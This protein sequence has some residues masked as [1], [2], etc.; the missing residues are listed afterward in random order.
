[1]RKTEIVVVDLWAAEA[2]LVA[3]EAKELGMLKL[4]NAGEKIHG[5]ML[6][7]TKERY[8]EEVAQSKY[9]YKTAKQTIH[10]LNYG[11]EESVM[12]RESRLPYTICAWQRAMY[13]K[14]FPGI[15][16]RQRLIKQE[17]IES[18]TLTSLLGRRRF[19]VMPMGHPDL[20]NKAYAW[21]T[22]SAIGELTNLAAN[23]LRMFS[24]IKRR[25]FDIPAVKHM[26]HIR[27]GL[28]THDGLV[29]FSY[30][31][32][33]PLVYK[34]LTIAFCH[35]FTLPGSAEPLTIPISVYY[36]ENFNDLTEDSVIR[37][38]KLTPKDLTW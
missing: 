28:N 37:Y 27:L 11:A 14:E 35:K 4:L 29:L 17:L 7:K 33:R 25:N 10:A 9:V 16:L 3:L 32:E 1:M 22:Q 15:Q 6:Q 19:F 38:E 20:L 21:R 12:V 18:S 30:V 36:G 34:A 23:K 24:R 26:P 5:W 13:Y 31:D 8:P 2:Y